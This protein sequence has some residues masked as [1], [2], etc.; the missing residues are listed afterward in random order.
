[1]HNYANEACSD[2]CISACGTCVVH[3]HVV[4]VLYM[5]MWYMMWHV[6]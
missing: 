5:C 3:V 1:M 2:T 4:H 6:V